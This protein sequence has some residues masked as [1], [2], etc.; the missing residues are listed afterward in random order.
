MIDALSRLKNLI[1]DKILLNENLN[2]KITFNINFLKGIK[3][4]DEA[5][6]ELE[7]INGKLMLTNSILESKKIGK[8]LFK[9]SVLNID[10]NKTILK[11][12]I[13]FDIFNQKKFY[14]KLLI[15]KNDRIK[16]N[17]IYFEIEK[18]LNIDEFEIKKIVLNKKTKGNSSSKTIDLS[19][20][21]NVNEINQLKNW[22]ELK[23]FSSEMFSK[24]SK[25]N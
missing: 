21:I 1:D 14:Q 9:D 11:S 16:L 20:L 19:D 7:I 8:M 17:N 4:F 3:F 25:L 13:L 6:I 2:G 23:K 15:S 22:I 10:D 5:K 24:V 18:D 12:K